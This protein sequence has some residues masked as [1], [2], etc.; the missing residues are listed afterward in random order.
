MKH[1]VFIAGVALV[2]AVSSVS[3]A[4]A[5]PPNEPTERVGQCQ[6]KLEVARELLRSREGAEVVNAAREAVEACQIEGVSEELAAEAAI[7]RS[8][9]ASEPWDEQLDWITS[10]EERLKKAQIRSMVLVRI[11]EKKADLIFLLGQLKKA[12]A[13]AEEARDLRFEIFGETSKEALDGESFLAHAHVAAAQ[14]EK[15]EYHR[16]EAVAILEAALDRVAGSSISRSET[17]DELRGAIQEIRRDLGELEPTN[18]E[19]W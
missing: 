14:V 15:P 10:A 13:V 19:E 2:S 1:Q 4:T 18:T 5:L 8:Q 17:A 16:R 6:E 9:F 3:V 12:F 7:L 11:L